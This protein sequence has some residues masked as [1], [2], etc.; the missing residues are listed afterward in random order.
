M[1]TGTIKNQIDQIWNAFWTG[2]IANPLEVIEQITYLLFLKRL[3]D[4]HTLRERRIPRRH[5]RPSMLF[6]SASAQ[7][8]IRRVADVIEA[9]DGITAKRL[10]ETI[11]HQ[12]LLD[13][14][15]NIVLQAGALARY[16]W[17]TR[18]QVAAHARRGEHLRAS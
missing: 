13:E 16:F 8:S 2:G 7:R 9:I 1:I 15:Q 11:D 18:V 3:D 10:R 6:N 14:L 17:P 4:L 5:G 12:R